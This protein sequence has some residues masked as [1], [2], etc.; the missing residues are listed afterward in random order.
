V[1]VREPTGVGNRRVGVDS[2]EIDYRGLLELVAK[3]RADVAWLQWSVAVPGL[4]WVRPG[5]APS[6]ARLSGF[7][8]PPSA[9]RWVDGALSRDAWEEWCSARGILRA[10]VA[11]LST[12]GDPTGSIGVGSIASVRLHAGDLDA[13]GLAS[14]LATEAFAYRQHVRLGMA[15]M[16][17]AERR[18]GRKV[19][20]AAL[21]RRLGMELHDDVG[22]GLSTLLLRVRMALARGSAGRAELQLLED[23]AQNILDSTRKLGQALRR[24]EPMVEP[25][26]GARQFAQLVTEAAGCSLTW[27]DERIDANAPHSAGV[28]ASVIRE[29]LTNIIRHARATTVDVH[30]VTLAGRTQVTIRDDGV[31]FLLSEQFPHNGDG[32]IGLVGN[33]E[34]LGAIGGTFRLESVPGH[35]TKVIFDA[36]LRR[37]E[38]L[39]VA[40]G[41]AQ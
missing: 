23:T 30:L 12:W 18:R 17:R 3:P 21:R 31:G 26:E 38:R 14:W 24:G 32:G 27:R 41:R 1:T 7:P 11:P 36:P 19:A 8:E 29:S 5:L 4:T 25:L 15:R 39:V 9:T 40:A 34:R 35:G 37:S 20:T 16:L 6:T 28:L 22:Q 33:R 13:L 10:A 2:G